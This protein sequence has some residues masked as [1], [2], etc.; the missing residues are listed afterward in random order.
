MKRPSL[1]IV[2]LGSEILVKIEAN[3]FCTEWTMMASGVDT[4]QF[5]INQANK[6]QTNGV[7]V[8]HSSVESEI[9]PH[10]KY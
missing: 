5:K 3:L 8:F 1:N 2:Q 7:E 6:F 4:G 9:M 10:H